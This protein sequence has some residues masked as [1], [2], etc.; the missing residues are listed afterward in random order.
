V[1]S[2]PQLMPNTLEVIPTL[3]LKAQYEPIRDEIKMA[4]DAVLESQHFILGPEVQSLEREIASYVGSKFGV[5]VA[6]GTDALILALK[7]CDVGAGDEVLCPSFTFIATA[8]AVSLL[9]AKPVFIDIDPKTFMMDPLKLEQAISLRTKAVIPVHLYGQAADMDAVVEIARKHNLRVI[10]DCAQA[11]GATYKGKRVGTF[12]DLG[13]FSFF[14]SKNL[15]GYGDGGMVVTD[16]ELLAKRLRSLRSHGAVKK[17]FSEE[18]GWNSRLDEI[19]AAILRVKLRHLETWAA[20]RRERAARYDVLLRN[21]AEVT[22]PVVHMSG[23]HV[24]HQYTIRVPNRDRVQNFL[25]EAGIVTAV[26]YP[27]PIHLQPIYRSLG[28]RSGNLPET[29]KAAREVLS[30]PIYPELTEAQVQR[31]ASALMGA[32]RV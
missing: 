30:L 8:D 5:G 13:C 3:D 28:Y 21:V 16:S 14:P 12:G 31:I 26:Y 19:Q 32:T 11:I 25:A 6:S 22:R 17:Y 29:E 7:S 18:Q 24:F 4:I 20:A 27:T 10:E 2:Q 15:G 23:T 1:A 9:G